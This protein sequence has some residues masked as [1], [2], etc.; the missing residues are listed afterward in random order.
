MKKDKYYPITVCGTFFTESYV[1]LIKS[2]VIQNENDDDYSLTEFLKDFFETGV[3]LSQYP[4]F[5][6]DIVMVHSSDILY[7][8]E[9]DEPGYYLGIPFFEVP[10]HF[11]IKRICIDVRNL[12]ISSG[13]MSDDVH[14]DSVKVFTKILKVQE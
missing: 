11:S 14:P 2:V 10:E 9:I 4:S 13:F 7:D 12:F 6:K 5:M 1:S 8:E 3:D